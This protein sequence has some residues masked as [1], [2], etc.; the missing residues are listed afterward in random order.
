MLYTPF[1]PTSDGALSLW[2]KNYKE[3]ITVYSATLGMTA[4][5]VDADVA[6]CEKMIDSIAAVENFKAQLA[7]SVKSKEQTVKN[8]GGNLKKSIAGHKTTPGYTQAIGEDLG[9]VGSSTEFNPNEYKAEIIVEHYGGKIKIRFL[10]LGADGINLYR[11]NKGETAWQLV[12]RATKSPY[13]YLPVL[14][15]PNTPVHI[16]FRAFGVLNDVEIG[17]PSDINEILFGE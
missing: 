14:M 3:K 1:F 5:E 13:M 9:I 7:G 12:T 2:C 11:R 17:S 16:E 8:D 6:F 10:K 4:A 15:Q